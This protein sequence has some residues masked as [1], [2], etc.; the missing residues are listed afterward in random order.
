MGSVAPSS[1]ALGT[2]SWKDHTIPTVQHW[3]FELVLG[4]DDTRQTRYPGCLVS[5]DM[6]KKLVCL[7]G[8][9]SHK[10]Y[11]GAGTG[12]T[13]VCA[14]GNGFHIP[15]ARAGQ[16]KFHPRIDNLEWDTREKASPAKLSLYMF[17]GAAERSL[18][19]LRGVVC[20]NGQTMPLFH[21]LPLHP[22]KSFLILMQGSPPQI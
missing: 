11:S 17:L 2:H 12:V 18:L 7:V 15:R 14:V 9:G 4:N 19:C 8:G 16:L 20:V 10:S 1:P 22:G 21:P 13:S 6:N 3:I 5:D